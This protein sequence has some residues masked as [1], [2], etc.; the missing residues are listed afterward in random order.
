MRGYVG[1]GLGDEAVQSVPEFVPFNFQLG[2]LFAQLLDLSDLVLEGGVLAVA[3]A[4]RPTVELELLGP[5]C[6]L[7][8]R[9]DVPSS[10]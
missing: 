3:L 5:D 4:A 6:F 8:Y 9:R 10:R 1:L 7:A 2:Q